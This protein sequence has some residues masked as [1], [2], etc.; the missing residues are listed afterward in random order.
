MLYVLTFKQG[1]TYI[2]A[3]IIKESDSCCKAAGR[4]GLKKSLTNAPCP[5][6]ITYT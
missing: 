6:I 5:P 1:Y 3:A 2:T 4:K